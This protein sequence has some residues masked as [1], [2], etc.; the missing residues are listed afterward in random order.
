MAHIN[1][2]IHT[3]CKNL[4]HKTMSTNKCK[5]PINLTNNHPTIPAVEITRSR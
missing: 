5:N 3:H 1:T 4:I 2:S